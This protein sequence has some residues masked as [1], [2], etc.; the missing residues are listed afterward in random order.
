MRDGTGQ[1]QDFTGFGVATSPVAP[2]SAR[3]LGRAPHPLPGQRREKEA[4]GSQRPETHSKA[5]LWIAAARCG[6]ARKC[7]ATAATRPRCPPAPPQPAPGPRG[8]RRP[9]PP[10][11]ASAPRWAPPCR[12]PQRACVRPARP[13]PARPPLR[14]HHSRR[15]A[16]C[17]RR[18]VKA[19]AVM[20]GLWEAV[21]GRPCHLQPRFLWKNGVCTARPQGA[22]FGKGRGSAKLRE[23]KKEKKN[24]LQKWKETGVG[25]KTS[26]PT[27]HPRRPGPSVEPCPLPQAGSGCSPFTSPCRPPAP[28]LRN[29]F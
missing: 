27:S 21:P 18:A 29:N 4:R 9:P 25:C 19:E 14:H 11:S 6:S 3:G 26:S 13:G 20:A 8:C 22:T 2:P 7:P 16:G 23:K 24:P 17:R 1:R 28:S 15:D 12:S 10:A 5:G